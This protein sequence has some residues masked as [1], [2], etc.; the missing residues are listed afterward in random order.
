MSSSL[1]IAI[2][3]E[4]GYTLYGDLSGR[5][6]AGLASV[7]VAK[8]LRVELVEETASL[9]LALAARGGREKT[10]EKN[11]GSHQVRY[12]KKSHQKS[13]YEIVALNTMTVY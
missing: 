3:P 10:K 13:E 9:S 11:R 6:A 5:E 12:V 2:A 8:G 4:R 7:L 1:Q